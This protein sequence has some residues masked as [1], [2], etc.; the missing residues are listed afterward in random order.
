V[1]TPIV[2]LVIAGLGCAALWLAWSLVPAPRQVAA[3]PP[4][5][6][7]ASSDGHSLV[8]VESVREPRAVEVEMQTVRSPTEEIPLARGIEE[9]GLATASRPRVEFAVK[10][11]GLRRPALAAAAER[12][13]KE[14]RA[15]RTELDSKELEDLEARVANLS[16]PGDPTPRVAHLVDLIDERAWVVERLSLP[17]IE[18]Q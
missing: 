5:A 10:Y 1:R 17:Q 18:D 4:A 12:L 14:I 3:Q 16:R 7:A 9:G 11:M 15:A 13:S 6:V 2:I 8:E